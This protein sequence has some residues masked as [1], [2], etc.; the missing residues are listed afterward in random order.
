MNDGL[1]DKFDCYQLTHSTAFDQIRLYDG[2]VNDC[3]LNDCKGDSPFSYI[4]T[5]QQATV[6]IMLITI[7]HMNR[8]AC[9]MV[10][11]NL[12]LK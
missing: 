5:V 6:I 11:Q 4:N 9:T 12:I 2:S 3:S 10:T 7:V 1:G 8:L